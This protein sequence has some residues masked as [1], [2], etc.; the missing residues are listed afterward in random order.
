MVWPPAPLELEAATSA[1]AAC[2]TVGLWVQITLGWLAPTAML[3]W[4]ASAQA[5]QRAGQLVPDGFVFYI[6]FV[7]QAIWCFVRVAVLKYYH[8]DGQTS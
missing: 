5:M 2:V 7:G 1:R 3:A 4:A 6:F 8:V